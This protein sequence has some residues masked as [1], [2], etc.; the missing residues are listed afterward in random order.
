MDYDS[1]K[2][3]LIKPHAA[4]G[5]QLSLPGEMFTDAQLA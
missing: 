4:G 5:L 3:F 2:D 1:V